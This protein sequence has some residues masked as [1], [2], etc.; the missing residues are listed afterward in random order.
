MFILPL[1][2]THTL[3]VSGQ[4]RGTPYFV[5]RVAEAT[6]EGKKK[7]RNKK[8]VKAQSPQGERN[9]SVCPSVT[10]QHPGRPALPVLCG[11]LAL[12]RPGSLPP[13]ERSGSE[14]GR[15]G[16]SPQAA[17]C[18]RAPAA[19]D[20]GPRAAPRRPP[21]PGR[22]GAGPAA[23]ALRPARGRG[24]CSAARAP[25][26]VN[27]GAGREEKGNLPGRRRRPGGSGQQSSLLLGCQRAAAAAGSAAEAPREPVAQLRAARGGPR[28]AG[29]ERAGGARSRRAWP[30][31]GA[32]GGAPQA[33]PR[34]R[35][36]CR[37]RSCRPCRGRAMAVS[38]PGPRCSCWSW[39]GLPPPPR[40][41]RWGS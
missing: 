3:S 18:A 27:N 19:G 39:G 35:A 1:Q 22:E 6:F 2:Q 30:A 29:S 12:L 23:R 40:G 24:R 13:C 37:M 21:A 9:C 14:N 7:N 8:K 31:R 32:A 4:E 16:R 41:T 28:E 26:A 34:S 17:S 15:G 33:G 20:P 10:E 25:T 5:D 11:L 36:G 38:A